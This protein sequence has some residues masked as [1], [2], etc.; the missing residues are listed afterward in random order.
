MRHGP[1]RGLHRPRGWQRHSLLRDS[2]LG[3]AREEGAHHRGARPE[4]AARGPGGLGG[5]GRAAVRVLP[6]RTGDGGGL[7][8]RREPA[9]DGRRHRRRHERQP[10]PLRHLPP[11]PEGDPPGGGR[12]G[13]GRPA[14]SAQ[15]PRRTFLKGSAVAG[16]GLIL[17]F[18]LPGTGGGRAQAEDA[19]PTYPPNAFIRIRPDGSVTFLIGKSEMGQG[20]YTALA[21]LIA[22]QLECDWSKVRVESAPVAPV[23]NH[24]VFGMQLTGGSTSVWSSWDQMQ[25]V[26]A[27]ARQ[28][29]ITAAAQKWGVEAASCRAENSFVLHTPSGRRLPYGELA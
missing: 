26:G 4:D 20:V 24:T 8:A 10:L 18:W 17:G 21:M 29:L 3:G 16:G 25:K 15:L 22:E 27:T 6:V 11:D 19:P 13:E 23:Y 7:P 1:L 2:G 9:A 14:V 12:A 5:G 28:M